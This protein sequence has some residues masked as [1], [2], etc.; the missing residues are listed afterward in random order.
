M[1][2]LRKLKTMARQLGVSRAELIEGLES[3]QEKG[4]ITFQIVRGTHVRITETPVLRKAREEDEVVTI[5]R[6]RNT[7]YS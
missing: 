3:L 5:C 4:L 1:V 7:S 6:D 2:T